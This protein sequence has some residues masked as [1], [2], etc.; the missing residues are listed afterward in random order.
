MGQATGPDEFARQFANDPALPAWAAEVVGK[1]VDGDL[2]TLEVLER[3]ADA[4]AF[5]FAKGRPWLTAD[6]S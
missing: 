6:P 4:A 1:L 2:P 3:L 5:L